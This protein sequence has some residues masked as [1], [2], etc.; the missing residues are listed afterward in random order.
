MADNNW[1]N[2]EL[3]AAVDTY[4]QM[5]TLEKRGEKFNKSYFIRKLIE[6]HLPTSD[7]CPKFHPALRGVLGVKSLALGRHLVH[8]L[9]LQKF[10]W[11]QV[12]QC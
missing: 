2:T 7:L 4:F 3:K 5:L 9:S 1:T 10:H 8:R 6:Q 11:C 12:A